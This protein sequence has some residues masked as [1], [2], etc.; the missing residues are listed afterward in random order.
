MCNHNAH[1]ADARRAAHAHRHGWGPQASQ[2]PG[3]QSAPPANVE[4]TDD[5]FEIFLVAPGR[6]KEDFQL[7][8]TDDVLVISCDRNEPGN[9]QQRLRS[10][11]RI[12]PFERRF[13]LNSKI[14]ADMIRAR[15]AEGI[16][17]VTLPKR[18]E[19]SGPAQEII[20]A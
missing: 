16:L 18:P 3:R 10:E 7:R 17:Q 1:W 11:F 2:H 12:A 8:I 15:Y 4:E 13:Q 14:E 9:S 6:Q 5:S 19:F 20:V